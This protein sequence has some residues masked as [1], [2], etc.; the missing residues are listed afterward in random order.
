MTDIRRWPIDKF[1]VDL[2][3][4]VPSAPTAFESGPAGTVAVFTDTLSASQNNYNPAQFA[5]AAFAVLTTVGT[6]NLTG[7]VASFAGERKTIIN[8]GSGT[9]V[10]KNNSAS[11]SAA[12]RFQVTSDIA[13]SPG[14]GL[15]F[16]YNWL[17]N[18]WNALS[19]ASSGGGGGSG[20]VT[21]VALTAPAQFA[22][23]GSPVTI[24]GSLDIT[25]NTQSAN[26]VLAGPTN[27]AAAAP[28]FR[29]LVTADLSFLSAFGATLIDDADAATARATLGLVIGTNVQAYDATLA[30]LAALGTAADK[31][32][33]TTGIDTWAETALTAFAR[34]LIDDANAGTA[35]ATLGLVIGT[36]VQAYDATLASL[37]ALGTA[38]DKIA[39][40]TGIDTWAETALT[41][42]ARSILDDASVGA[43]ATTLGLGTGDSPQFTAVNIG[44]ASDT[45]LTR[46][47]AGVMA[48][49]GVTILTTATGQ[50]L[51]SDLTTIAGLTATTDNF[52]QAK[53]SAWASRTPTQVTADL[54]AMVGDSGAGGTKG[55]VP[56]PA[57]GDA[58]A[59]K[60]LKA[61][62]TWAAS[63]S[64]NI[65]DVPVTAILNG[66]G[67]V[68]TTGI[69]GDLEIPFAG[70]I[71]A[72]RL[73][74]DQSGSIVVDIWK[75]TYANYPPTIADTIVASA[76]PTI[77]T[78]LKSQDT[79]LTGWT[80]SVSAGD[81]LRFN[82][83]SVS[84]IT[85]CTVS[86]TIRKTP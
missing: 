74:A 27:G 86:L 50:P 62:G 14:V 41:A 12:N 44:H 5:D 43:I 42:A 2:T 20:S 7:M 36:N 53:A 51:D 31:I 76:P 39:Y 13:L 64:N 71:T 73:F 69:A 48:I 3:K 33:Y 24:A 80:T 84:S 11:S 9:L 56:A 16:W 17:S 68:L 65:R 52:M 30:S 38:A 34:T 28:T 23:A 78:A 45:T 6:I 37:S 81:I 67:S 10:I 46:V 75:D 4:A 40:T 82:I 63:V 85:R 57:A 77:S 60:F 83:N 70:V 72:V 18:C 29:A 8:L 58:A 59:L 79:T 19:A 25:W 66:G 21:S 26:F 35:Q 22:V 49:E 54:I 32:A 55:L 1:P 15:E 61:D 47:S